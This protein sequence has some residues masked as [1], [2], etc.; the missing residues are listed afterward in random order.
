MLFSTVSLQRRQLNR[1][2]DSINWQTQKQIWWNVTTGNKWSEGSQTLS[3]LKEVFIY[4]HM[5]FSRSVVSDSFVT[6]WTV[7]HQAPLSME[8]P[9]KNTGMHCYFLL[10][11]IFP[12]QGSN[13]R[14]LHWQVDSVPL[15]HQGSPIYLHLKV[16]CKNCVNCTNINNN[17]L[18]FI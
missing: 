11:G 3:E 16:Y 12:S 8:F 7:V 6:P 5:L 13:L 4:I 18:Q 1:S 14:L 17:M 15:S 2:R 10:Q 9:G